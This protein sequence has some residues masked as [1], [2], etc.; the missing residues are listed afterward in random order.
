M[1]GVGKIGL[2]ILLLGLS[3]PAASRL[4]QHAGQPFSLPA[5]LMRVCHQAPAPRGTQ[6]RP[7]RHP[8]EPVNALEQQTRGDSICAALRPATR[9]GKTP[10]LPGRRARVEG[11][12]PARSLSGPAF[13]CTFLI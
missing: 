1:A 5:W 13:L 11:G 12:H 7:P 3:L 4:S 2:A 8:N 9:D 6:R 10:A